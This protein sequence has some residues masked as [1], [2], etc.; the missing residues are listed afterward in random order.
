MNRLGGQP[1]HEG[2]HLPSMTTGCGM[3]PDAAEFREEVR[4][5]RVTQEMPT[6]LVQSL[7][8][9][10][11]QAFTCQRCL[12]GPALSGLQQT[13]GYQDDNFSLPFM[14]C[15]LTEGILTSK[16]KASSELVLQASITARKLSEQNEP[17]GPRESRSGWE[18]YPHTAKH[19]CTGL[20]ESKLRFRGHLRPH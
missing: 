7:G 11:C 3:S 20:T 17:G 19:C 10:G 15:F 14:C 1:C 13:A 6:S 8:L 9:L 12:K 4:A 2:P 5:G 18:T 16:V